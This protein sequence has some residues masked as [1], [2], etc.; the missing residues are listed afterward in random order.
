M[1]AQ[2][3]AR[4]CVIQ[5]SDLSAS[6]V[7]VFAECASLFEADREMGREMEREEMRR[8][9]SEKVTVGRRVW[10]GRSSGNASELIPS[11]VAELVAIGSSRTSGHA[12]SLMPRGHKWW[13]M[14]VSIPRWDTSYKA[15]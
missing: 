15:F 9:E 14:S 8:Q 11:M 4:L 7:D 3:I 1:V 12:A 2:R 6:E 13:R 10:K 5:V